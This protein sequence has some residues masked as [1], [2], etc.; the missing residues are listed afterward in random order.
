M[1]GLIVNIV[2]GKGDR[3]VLR[4]KRSK[5][6]VRRAQSLNTKELQLDTANSN[7]SDFS[8]KG[9]IISSNSIDYIRIFVLHQRRP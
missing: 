4:R 9:I 1:P 2:V 6:T 3:D 5:N 7:Y 8:V